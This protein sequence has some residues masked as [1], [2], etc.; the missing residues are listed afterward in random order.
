MPL[1]PASPRPPR[2][3]A[4]TAAPVLLVAALVV[5]ALGLIAAGCGG[6][7]PAGG[8]PTLS[9]R[10][11]IQRADELQSAA[12]DVFTTPDA[13]LPATPAQAAPRIAALD[14][15]VAGYERLVPPADWKDEHAAILESLGDMRTALVVV[16]K[17]S[18]KNRKAIEFQVGRYQD[19]QRRYDEAIT[20]I[21]AS[22]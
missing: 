4:A 17:A 20:S 16:S 6:D 21:N 5:V 11:Y 2:P 19:A 7:D 3:P 22:R 15:L 9:K 1:V 13:R 14:D 10:D 12:A 8:S 18:A